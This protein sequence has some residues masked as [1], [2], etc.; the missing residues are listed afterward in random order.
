MDQ[1]AEELA[2]HVKEEAEEDDYPCKFESS[3]ITD[4]I[5]LKIETNHVK[6]YFLHLFPSQFL[7]FIF[8]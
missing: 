2:N 6:P 8:Q 5:R 4:L 3:I 7:V 1:Q